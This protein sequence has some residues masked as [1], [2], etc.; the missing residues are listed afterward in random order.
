MSQVP[1][2]SRSHRRRTAPQDRPLALLPLADHNTWYYPSHGYMSDDE[3]MPPGSRWVRRGKM[4]A[5]GPQ[6][7]DWEAEERSRKRLKPLLP[8]TPPAERSPSPPTLPHLN[9]P[10]TPPMVMP[11]PEPERQHY[12]YTSFV[13][14]KAVTH[15][16]RSN[17]LY[18]LEESTNRLIEGEAEMKRT[19]GRLWQVINESARVSIDPNDDNEPI[20]PKE[21]EGE[22]QGGTAQEKIQK[23]RRR[24]RAKRLARAPDVT[25]AARK[26]F[27]FGE[28][29]M[30]GQ[31]THFHIHDH[32]NLEKFISTLHELADD[33]REY[34]ERLE[35]IRNGLG[36]VRW[37]R[38]CMWEDVRLRAIGELHE[39]A[40]VTEE[41]MDDAE[42]R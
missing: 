39:T 7:E 29:D 28:E 26:V 15:T 30:P 41:L 25:P 19:L 18:E 6:M 5:W 3:A 8:T 16:F 17:L 32:D 36:D 40:K 12:T 21:E 4:A 23:E 10:R 2:A 31:T 11:F 1:H 9:R 14:D 22:E 13:M 38:D 42:S 37:Q 33:G 24:E 35:E 20:E 34:V 27:L